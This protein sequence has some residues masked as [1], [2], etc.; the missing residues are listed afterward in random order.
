MSG[1]AESPPRMSTKRRILIFLGL[2]L[3]LALCAAATVVLYYVESPGKLKALVEQSV[4]RAIG[5]QCSISE[6]SYSLNPLSLRAGGIQLIDPVQRFHLD[7]AALATELSLQ[8]SF[9]RRTLI[10]KHL[11]LQG[12]SLNSDRSSGLMETGKKPAASGF[13]S[14][15]AKGLVALLLFR[16]IRIENAEL[17]GGQVNSDM[18]GQLLTMSGIHLS[19]NEAQ[20]LQVSCHAR[21]RWPSEETE[22]TMPRLRLTADRAFSIFDPEIRMSLRGEEMTAAT[23]FG[24]AENLSGEVQLL[25]DRDKKLLL[26][27][28]ARLSSE[29]LTLRQLNG[30][31]SPSLAMTL[32]V[33]GFV[34]F[35]SERAGVER[36]HLMLDQIVEA[37]GAF[38]AVMGAHPQVKLSGLVLQLT[39]RNTWPLLAE[40][41]GITPSSFAFGGVAYVTGNLDGLLEGNVW[42]WRGDLQTR[43]KD[44]DVAFTAPHTRGRGKVTADIRVKGLYP[45]LETALTFAVE[46][47]E[48]SWKGI[49]VK[50]ARAAFAASGEGLDF[51]VQDLDFQAPQAEFM[52]GGKRVQV[53]DIRAQMPRGTVHSTQARLNFPRIDL[54]TSLVKNLQLSLDAHEGQVTFGLEGKEVGMLSLTQALSLV[55]PDWQLGGLDSFL[56]KGSL[57]EDGRWLLESKWNLD[58]VAFQSPDLRYAGEKISLD[59]HIRA[60]GSRKETGWATS[61]EGGAAN[62]GLLY[63][64]IYLDLQRNSLHFQFQGDY[65]LSDGTTGIS[66]FQFV[67]KDLLALE[68]EGQLTDLL[69]QHPCHLRVRLP[70][71]PLKPAFQRLLKDPLQQEVPFLANLDMGGDLTAEMDFQRATEG[72]RLLCRC[73]WRGGEILGKGITLQGIE[74]DVPL[75]GENPGSSADSSFEARFPSPRDFPRE[76]S[77]SIQSAALPYLPEQS[78]AVRAHITPNSVSFIPRDSVKIA[79]GEI[80]LDPISLKGLFTLSPSFATGATL[81]GIDLA[82]LLLG[83]WPHP[84]SGAIQGRL[85]HVDFDGDRVQTRGNVDVRAFGGEILLSNLGASG[86]LGA[87]PTL[88]LDATWKNLNLA[89]LT[90]GT[91]FD[92]IEGILQGHVK[93]LEVVGK[94]PQRFDLFL[95]TARTEEVPQKI[96]V[97]ALENIARIGG[98]ESPFIGLAGA[99]TSLFKEFPYDKIAVQASLENDVFRI[100]GPLKE[101]GKVYLVKRSGFSGVNIVN[102]D[103]EQRIS[104]KDM[105]KRIKRVTASA[106]GSPGEEQNPKNGN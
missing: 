63:D 84:L 94:E 16:D 80:E 52:L 75:W 10:V 50:S 48:F 68:G 100:G 38:H 12:F 43:L 39:L 11:T 74:L 83:L 41:C 103:P 14:R 71:M 20:S 104:F 4:G 69:L 102:Q 99:L 31:V 22:V 44:G 55:P 61:V 66:G 54:H 91:P 86:V 93:H 105:V 101:G 97:R 64:R 88:L 73:S 28:S 6:F 36:F 7:I 37:D 33:D 9:T 82:P 81:R 27:N 90:A 19:L 85:D 62:G 35:S 8:G 60:S 32:D 26:L 42:R 18:G 77:L 2:A 30:S 47:A 78:F 79:G 98:G 70:W 59:L 17:S 106:G 67:L 23:P 95:E 51:D 40:A 92:K 15:L 34:D 3:L 25:Y 45:A 57:K 1:R 76:G 87:T 21:L 65:D 53:Q 49:G 13:V 29:N 5:T 58:Q 24:K 56:V 89:E 72:W 46:K 96:S